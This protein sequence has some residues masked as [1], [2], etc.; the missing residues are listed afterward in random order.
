MK[1]TVIILIIIFLSLSLFAKMG[2]KDKLQQKINAINI[3]DE[4]KVSLIAMIPIFE[5][6]GAIPIGIKHYHLPYWKTF[7]FSVAG[8][9]IPIF[10]ILLFFDIIT[11][12]FFKIPILKKILLKIFERTRKKSASIEKY[13][14]LGLMLFVAIPLPV[15]G[16]WTGSLA[17]YLFGLNFWKSIL[18]I[19]LGVLIAGIVVS[20]LTSMGWIGAIIFFI[21]LLIV[22]IKPIYKKKENVK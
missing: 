16:A 12:L 17:A 9:M 18:F 14:E 2:L 5:L 8:N 6:R 11:K 21:A 13:E 19:F 20:L 1:K 10:F 22:L 7:V 15:T 4:L 3:S